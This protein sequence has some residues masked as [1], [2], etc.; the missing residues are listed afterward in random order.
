MIRMDRRRFRIKIVGIISG[1]SF[2]IAIPHILY[3]ANYI[4][5]ALA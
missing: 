5:V 4:G 3:L 1:V 2:L